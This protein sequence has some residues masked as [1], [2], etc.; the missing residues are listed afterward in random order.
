MQLAGHSLEFVPAALLRYRYRDT[1]RGIF[2]QARGYG[3]SG[4]MLYKKYKAMGM[5]RRSPR[6]AVRFW[7][8]PIRAGLR[9]RDKGDLAF[10]LFLVGYRVGLAKGSITERVAYF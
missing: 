9:I 2:K 3:Y 10:W 6:T 5:P 8:G 7:L 4:P 1:L